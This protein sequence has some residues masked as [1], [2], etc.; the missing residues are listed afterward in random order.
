MTD[1]NQL[2]DDL[3][4]LRTAVESH[5]RPRFTPAVAWLWAAYVLV[6]YT[7]IDL[8]PRASAL[9]FLIG[10]VCNGVLTAILARR[11][12]QRDGRIDRADRRHHLLGWFGGFVLIVGCSVALQLTNRALCGTPGGQIVVVMVGLMYFLGG[13]YGPPEMHY[14]VW[15]GPIVMAGG[16]CVGLVPHYGWTALGVLIAAIILLPTFRSPAIAK[17]VQP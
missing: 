13:V 4:F 14:M 8:A 9:F 17:P 16:V 1:I 3:R 6:G 10:G 12:Q 2:A 15:G 7:L 5:Q 11:A